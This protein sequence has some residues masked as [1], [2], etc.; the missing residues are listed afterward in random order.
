[1]NTQYLK[2]LTV[3]SALFFLSSCAVFV[4]DGGH[5]HRGHWRHSSL[6]QSDQSGVQLTAQNSGGAQGHNQVRR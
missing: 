2:I 6:Q 3:V 5:R 4:E 1:M